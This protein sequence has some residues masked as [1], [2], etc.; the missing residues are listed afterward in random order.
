MGR[1]EEG[2]R[3]SVGE[4]ISDFRFLYFTSLLWSGKAKYRAAELK[5]SS[6]CA[7]LLMNDSVYTFQYWKRA[8]QERG[9]IPTKETTVQH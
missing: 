7:V 9:V 2:R 1:K 6:M 8:D 4:S 5:E 3:Q